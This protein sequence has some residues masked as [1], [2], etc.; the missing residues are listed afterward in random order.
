M[1][2][3]IVAVSGGVDSVVLLHKLV[4]K[5]PE[6]VRYVVAHYD[7][8]MRLDSCKDKKFVEQIAKNLQLA[9]EAEEGKLGENASEALA[10]EKRYEFLHQVKEKYQADRIITAH[11]QDDV[12]ETMIINI[13]R[14]TGPRGLIS[15]R[16]T[17]D[18]LRPLLQVPKSA[19][20]EY[21]KIHDLEWREDPSNDS[22]DYLRNYVRHHVMPQ[23]EPKRHDL[24]AARKRIEDIYFEV[25]GLLE[26][27]V[28]ESDDLARWPLLHFSWP[29]QREIMR[30]WLLSRGAAHLDKQTIERLTIAAKTLPA[31]KKVDVDESLWLESQ[32]KTVTAVPKSRG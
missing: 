30:T 19:L 27:V 1:K 14:G 10:R 22:D 4:A 29:V 32:K 8:G 6:D 24:L 31:G 12:L 28:P 7:H 21:A 15:L 11:H 2:K 3:F 18:V 25:D 20:L 13:L 26:Y 16:N 9:F 5:R 17:K 23:L